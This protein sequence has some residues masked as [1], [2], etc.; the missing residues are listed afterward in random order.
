MAEHAKPL[1][2]FTPG[3]EPYW[4]ACNRHELRLQRCSECAAF[5][6]YPSPMCHEPDCMGLD[7]DWAEVSGRGEVHTF[8][9]VHRPVSEAWADDAPYV[10]AMIQLDE[11]PVMMS[12]VVDCS[13]DDVRIG[14]PVEVVFRDL[15]E[16]VTLPYFRPAS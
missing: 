1:P 7:Y 16:G 12:N 11:G 13:P 15:A 5:R 8:T 6:F 10:I 4:D 3:S 2:Q 14:L 9:V